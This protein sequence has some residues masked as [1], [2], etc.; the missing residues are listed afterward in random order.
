MVII[1][2]SS[3]QKAF[4]HL[5]DCG[6]LPV[7][8]LFITKMPESAEVTKKMAIITKASAQRPLAKGKL[9]KNE[10]SRMSGWRTRAESAPCTT[11]RS[12]QMAPLPKT[13]IHRKMNSEG[14]SITARMYSREGT[15]I[16]AR[17][18]SRMVRPLEMRAINRPTKGA[19][20]IH[21]AQN[22]TVQLVN[23]PRPAFSKAKV[24]N[25]RLAKL[26]M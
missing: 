24:L 13:V 21:H 15:S 23:H 6:L 19:H 17:M 11:L 4:C 7:E 26:S 8:M 18:Y 9:S 22:I 1:A 16:T 20:D 5:G 10:N 12:I 14:T 25:V 3:P 2:I